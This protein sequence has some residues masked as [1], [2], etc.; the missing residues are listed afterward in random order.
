MSGKKPLFLSAPRM[1]IRLDGQTLAFAIGLSLNVRVD[2]QPI[3]AIGS[4]KAVS[5]EPIM[6]QPVTGTLQ[7]VRLASLK[8]R[9]ERLASAE[10]LMDNNVMQ[11]TSAIARNLQGETISTVTKDGAS[12]S[13]VSNSILGMGNLNAH[14]DPEQVLISQTFDLDVY[15]NI[16]SSMAVPNAPSAS[17]KSWFRIKD[18][19]LVSRN[20]NIRLGALVNEPVS[21]QGLLATPFDPAGGEQFQMDTHVTEA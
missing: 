14:L 21:F 7:I 12:V 5:L 1:I 9:S 10:Q 3:M 6:V 20:T 11:G 4:I 15:I 2:V 16:T 13:A 18:C 8:S 17:E 19:R